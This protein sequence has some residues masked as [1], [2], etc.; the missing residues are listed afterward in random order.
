MDHDG[1]DDIIV[2]DN[3]GSLYIFYGQSTGVFRMQLIENVYD[4]ILSDE[5]K[6]SYFTGAIRYT[7]S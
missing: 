4:F 1:I 5:A 2:L 3:L 6:T 7:G